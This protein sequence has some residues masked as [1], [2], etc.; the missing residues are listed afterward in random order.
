M[1]D[2]VSDTPVRGRVKK[3]KNPA[4]A[5][6]HLVPNTA[7]VISNGVYVKDDGSEVKIW[8][9]WGGDLHFRPLKEGEKSL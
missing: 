2:D 3:V 1:K 7:G 8:F 5:G 4:L 9:A 6:F